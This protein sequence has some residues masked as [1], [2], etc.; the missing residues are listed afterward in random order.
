M[1]SEKIKI[2]AKTGELIG[3]HVDAKSAEVISKARL[4]FDA[5]YLHQGMWQLDD[6][7]VTRGIII[8]E[9]MVEMVV[10]GGNICR[11]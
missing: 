11:W 7:R 8:P 1:R 6:S 4:M 9:K 2:S 5:K 3:I 10:A